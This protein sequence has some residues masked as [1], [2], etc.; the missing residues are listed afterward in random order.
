MLKTK[1]GILLMVLAVCLLLAASIAG[2]VALAQTG[3]NSQ[4]QATSQQDTLLNKVAQIYQTNTGVTLDTQ[5]LKDAFAKAQ[6]EMRDEALQNWLNNLVEEG[7][8]TQAEADA[9]L[10]WWK[11]R[12]DT[13]LTRDF[14][15]GLGGMMSRG[16]GH[17]FGGQFPC[18][19]PDTANAPDTSGTGS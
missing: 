12:P 15:L 7:K 18:Q 8:L 17:G 16:G 1:K 4:Y 2:V 5:Q 11:A 9:Y 19:P 3:S 14:D 6:S 10:N 13:G